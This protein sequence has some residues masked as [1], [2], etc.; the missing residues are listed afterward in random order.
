MRLTITISI[1]VITFLLAVVP[2]RAQETPVVQVVFFFN[3]ECENCQKVMT[4]DLPP[5]QAKY[6][7]QLE[8]IQVDTSMS[9]GIKLYQAMSRYFQLSNDRLGTPAIVIDTTVLVGADEIPAKLPGMIEEGLAKGGI[10]WPDIPGLESYIPSTTETNPYPASQVYPQPAA[11]VT[12]TIESTDI[13]T[14]ERFSTNFKKDPI[15]NS[16]AVITLVGMVIS[17]FI[18]LSHP[19]PK[20]ISRE[21][22][23]CSYPYFNLVDPPVDYYRHGRGW[24]PYVYRGW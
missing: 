21:S 17:I 19:V 16:L 18:V 14:W 22:N 9:E 5:L 15:A 7:T 20:C 1:I 11:Q 8:I 10:S 3:P 12:G 13:S 24:L 4:K 2:T 6:G 23:S